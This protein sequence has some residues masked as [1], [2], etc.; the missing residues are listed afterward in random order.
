MVKF[1][2]ELDNLLSLRDECHICDVEGYLSCDEKALKKYLNEYDHFINYWSSI[3]K[4]GSPQA[5]GPEEIHQHKS[6]SN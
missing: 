6:L 5:S 1:Q 2:I 4:N 3:I